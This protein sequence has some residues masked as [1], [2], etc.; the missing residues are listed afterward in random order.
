MLD[1]ELLHHYTTTSTY[2]TLSSDPIMRNYFLVDVPHLGFSHPYVLHSIIALA[3]SHLAHFRPESRQYYSAEA[4]ARHTSATSMATP[5]LS[6]ITAAN[7]IPIHCSSVLTMFIS[8]ASL[9][10]DDDPFFDAIDVLPSWFALF[11]GMRSILETNN[12]AIFSSSIL[13]LFRSRPHFNQDWERA[14]SWTMTP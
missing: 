14:S 9:G 5:L 7:A 6:E 4:T 12:R 2:L 13:F 8:F 11:R 1:L 10:E 3:A